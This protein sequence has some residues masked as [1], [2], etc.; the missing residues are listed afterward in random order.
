MYPIQDFESNNITH[1]AIWKGMNQLYLGIASNSN[2]SVFIWLGYYFDLVQVINHGTNKLIPFFS[3]GFMYIAA[4]GPT[5]LIFK[6][7]LRSNKF[8][9]TQRLPAS[10]DVSSFQLNE[11]HF[12]EHYLSLSMESFIIIYKE[13][14]DRFVPFQQ[15]S[16][17]SFTVPIISN[18]AIVLLSLY[19]DTILIYSYNGWRFVESNIKLSRVRK[20]HQVTLYGKELLLIK[21]KNDTWTLKQPIW[22]KKK[23][24]KDL[25]E[26]IRAWNMNA[27]NITQRISK[28]IP[29]SKNS[30]KIL[31][32]NID[33]LF[34]H[35]VKFYVSSK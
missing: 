24:H 13:I 35:N 25:Q 3:K 4:T 18:K 31:K 19:E 14:H 23:S 26:E 20:F 11:G 30:I 27:M 10:Q 17:G 32:G 8:T 29:D 2:I 33:Q 6:Y 12:M 9:V 15:I 7:F 1:L 34:V 16:P 21:Y 22:T 28:R 5:T